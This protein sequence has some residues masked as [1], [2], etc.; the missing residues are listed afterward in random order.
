MTRTT[1]VRGLGLDILAPSS[2][3]PVQVVRGEGARLFEA[4][5]H[6]LWDFYG[7]H[8]VALLGQGHPR[9]VEALAAQA[10]T[11]TFVSNLAPLPVRDEAIARLCAVA[12]ADRAFLVNSGAEANE[13]AL[14]VARKA[15]GRPVIVAMRRSFHGRTMAC[16]G[17]TEGGPYR[18]HHA[19]IHGEAR[20]VPFG[21]L[22]ALDAAMGPDV[23]GVFIE[24]IQGIAG[25]YEAPDG[26]LTA[27]RRICDRHGSLLMLDEIQTGLGRTGQWMAW[28]REPECR[29]DLVTIGKSLGSGFPV[30][31]LL[32]T[33]AMARSTRA[34]E[35][36][37]TYGGGPLA[38]ASIL[39]VIDII[40]R[41]DLLASALRVEAWVREGVAGMASV[42]EVRGKG[43]LLGLVLDRPARGVLEAIVH[44]GVLPGTASDPNCLR[45][46]PPALMPKEGVDA[47]V[48]GLR[49]VLA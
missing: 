47:L 4:S 42:R 17:V 20:F 34:G 23:A 6:A 48:A 43:A 41:E 44:H 1:D 22:D 30:A 15:T 35:H 24:P 21:D 3:L 10:R 29:P 49:L 9:W 36:G 18:A 38:C 45:L 26:F 27:A 31:G 32:M 11:L 16:L 40:E 25:V 7:G 28:H 19:P 2:M 37:T 46:C 12:R 39:A 8:A 14:K 5:G 33:E 13:A